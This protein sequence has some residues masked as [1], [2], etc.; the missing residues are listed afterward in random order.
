MAASR[1]S[2]WGSRESSM[3]SS[4]RLKELRVCTT[5]LGQDNTMHHNAMP[6]L[7]NSVCC[8]LAVPTT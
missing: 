3:A 8:H 1:S 4:Y 7:A 6:G 5:L 2:W